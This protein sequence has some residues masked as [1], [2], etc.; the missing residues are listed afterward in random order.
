MSS[1]Q[2]CLRKAPLI[3]AFFFAGLFSCH[4]AQD[5]ELDSYDE[6]ARIAKVYDGDTIRLTDGRKVRLIAIN[7]PELGHNHRPDQVFA[8]EAKQALESYFRNSQLIKLKFGKDKRDR[9]KRLL[10][11]VF[12]G[13]GQN[14]AAQ[15]LKQ[16]YGFAIAVPPNLWASECYFSMESSAQKATR[17][18][19]AHPNSFTKSPSELNQAQTGFY[20]I[21]GEVTRIGQS[22]KNVWLNLGKR[23]GIK[24]RRKDLG[25]FENTPI[26]ELEG[27]RIR[28]R[29][30][31]SFYNGK[32]RM[33][34]KHPAMLNIVGSQ[35]RD[36]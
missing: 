11:H 5:C 18:V 29:G 15:L 34:L 20:I 24:I 35:F 32:Y 27:K 8:Q 3:G 26:W 6:I 4:A 17:G 30:W 10:A 14:V 9:Y 13:T 22:K 19:W 23:L 25:Y 2:V 28:V 1:G 21:E 31:V 16:G 7:T 36:E 33:S 12:T